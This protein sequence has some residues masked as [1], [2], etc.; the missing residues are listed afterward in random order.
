MRYEIS[1]GGVTVEA[2]E[3]EAQF[4]EGSNPRWIEADDTPDGKEF[5][6]VQFGGTVFTA[7]RTED[8]WVRHKRRKENHEV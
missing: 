8:F 4:I 2:T 1:R 7:W 3:E 5:A 6:P